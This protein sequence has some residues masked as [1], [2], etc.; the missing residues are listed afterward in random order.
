LKKAHRLI[1]LALGSIAVAAAALAAADDPYEFNQARLQSGQNL[2]SEKKYLEAIDQFRIA[3]FGFLDKPPALS[4]ALIRLALAQTAASRGADADATISR[5]LEVERRFPSYPS[6]NISPDLQ[7]EFRTLLARRVT[8]A[9]LQSIPSLA[10]LVETEE[11]KIAKLPP[12]DRRKAFEAAARRDPSSVTWPIALA[13]DALSR[14]DPKEAE[15]WADKA[16]A[17]EPFNQEAVG[18]RA[19]ARVMRG[20]LAEA[21]ADVSALTPSEFE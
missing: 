7:A 10:G 21:R 14:S 11:Q 12:A 8:P 20:E 18:L 2:F 19:R 1:L 6:K 5:F 17:I 3:A 16:L 4:E 13:K 9:S 15:K